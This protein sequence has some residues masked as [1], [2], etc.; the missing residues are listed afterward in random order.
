MKAF[1]NPADYFI[2]MAQAPHLCS[3]D[4]SLEKMV[5]T[6][7]LNIKPK[8]EKGTDTRNSRFMNI[9]TK[10]NDFAERRSSSFCR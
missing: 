6:Y 5:D 1:C 7:D 3:K 4:L 2:K 8:I 9:S 10:F